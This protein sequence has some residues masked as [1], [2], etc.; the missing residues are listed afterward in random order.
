VEQING[1][2]TPSDR[3]STSKIRMLALMVL[4]CE[5]L[6]GDRSSEEQT[7]AQAAKLY[8]QWVCFLRHDRWF[9]DS[10]RP[11]RL[12]AEG[13]ALTARMKSFIDGLVDRLPKTGALQLRPRRRNGK[14]LEGQLVGRAVSIIEEKGRQVLLAMTAHIG[15]K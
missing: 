9:S 4:F 1:D 3:A 5:R 6:M 11:Q 15:G 14:V 12:S 2:A 10:T 8:D 13:E 7:R